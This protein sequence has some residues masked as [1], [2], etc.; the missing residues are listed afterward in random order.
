ML[1]IAY[2]VYTVHSVKQVVSAS[3]L[4]A[5]LIVERLEFS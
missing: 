4:I 2:S 3:E 5:W 1:A